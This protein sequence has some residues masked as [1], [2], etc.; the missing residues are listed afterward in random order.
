MNYQKLSIEELNKYPYPNLIAEIIYSGYSFNT[1]G[2]FM[3][4]GAKVN[5]HY[6][7]QDDKE[8]L[9]RLNGTVEISAIEALGLA[10]Y[11][12]ISF[13]YL[14]SKTLTVNAGKPEAYWRWLEENMGNTFETMIALVKMSDEHFKECIEYV[15]NTEMHPRT[16]E[17]LEK[18]LEIASKRRISAHE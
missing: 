15:K 8:I 4:I 14:F 3:G 13:E 7:T 6:R 9:D 10:H 17:F 5:G 18:C 16:R 2:D 12:N 1:I 11:Y